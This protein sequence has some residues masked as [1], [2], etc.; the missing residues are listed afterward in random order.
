M[1]RMVRGPGPN[2]R[3]QAGATT[4]CPQCGEPV[5]ADVQHAVDVHG[6]RWHAEC[7]LYEVKARAR[8]DDS[9]G[10]SSSSTG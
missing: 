5:P 10:A 6:E 4:M 2:R 8:G 1:V 7:V 3:D 9:G